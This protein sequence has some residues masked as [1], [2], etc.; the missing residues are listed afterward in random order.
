MTR[1]KQ[2]AESDFVHVPVDLHQRIRAALSGLADNEAL[3]PGVREDCRILLQELGG[4][5]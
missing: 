1:R 3:G 2:Y 5:A 4:K